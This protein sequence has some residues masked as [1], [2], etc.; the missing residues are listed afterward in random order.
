[1]NLLKKCEGATATKA[2]SISPHAG[3]GAL[4]AE[5]K[6]RRRGNVDRFFLLL[7]TVAPCKN[8]SAVRQSEAVT[9][10]LRY[11]CLE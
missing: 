6:K 3:A 7:Y 2:I 10:P 4:V 5:A 8:K 1:M 11:S 9:A